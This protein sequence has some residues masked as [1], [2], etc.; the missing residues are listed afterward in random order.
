M[1]REAAIGEDLEEWFVP[2]CFLPSLQLLH[3]CCSVAS[4][5]SSDQLSRD[6]GV[7]RKGKTFKDSKPASSYRK[8]EP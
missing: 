8:P 3:V 2:F 4:F 7:S 5:F 1:E 6:P